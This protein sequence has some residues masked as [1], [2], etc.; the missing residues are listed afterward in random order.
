MAFNKNL[1]PLYLIESALMNEIRAL[2]SNESSSQGPKV[3]KNVRFQTDNKSARSADSGIESA[4]GSGQEEGG[5]RN[6]ENWLKRLTEQR[7]LYYDNVHQLLNYMKNR[8][9]LPSDSGSQHT[10]SASSVQSLGSGS[11]PDGSQSNSQGFIPNQSAVFQQNPPNITSYNSSQQ[12]HRN[13]NQS[14]YHQPPLLNFQPPSQ[15]QLPTDQSTYNW[16]AG[17]P[18]APQANTGFDQSNQQ[19]VPAGR[20]SSQQSSSTFS[21]QN[22]QVHDQSHPNSGEMPRQ[23]QQPSYQWYA[24]SQGI[25]G[26]TN[27]PHQK[28]PVCVCG[29]IPPELMSQSQNQR[30]FPQTYQP[31]VGQSTYP[32]PYLD[33]NVGHPNYQQTYQSQPNAQ[34]FAQQPNFYPAQHAQMLATQTSGFDNSDQPNYRISR[35]TTTN[36]HDQKTQTESGGSASVYVPTAEELG[37]LPSQLQTWAQSMMQEK[38]SLKEKNSELRLELDEISENSQKS[39][40]LVNEVADKLKKAEDLIGKLQ[41]EL[42]ASNGKLRATEQGLTMERN[43][44]QQLRLDIDEADGNASSL[45]K[46]FVEKSTQ[47]DAA[48]LYCAQLEQNVGALQDQINSLKSQLEA[49][50]VN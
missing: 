25:S 22:R 33:P 10:I 12:P 43:N 14:P 7:Q 40:G 34:G 23:Q 9:S 19:Q 44:L 45:T 39:D 4:T 49:V 36:V 24:Q 8:Q 20:P 16:P 18:Y 41:S 30:G 11:R 26:Q 5:G 27:V 48:K 15:Q 31:G 35:P 13:M 6:R 17:Q 50:L 37:K 28:L 46:K 1:F 29:G 21:Q 47:L 2:V 3:S 38:K 32:Q 42:D